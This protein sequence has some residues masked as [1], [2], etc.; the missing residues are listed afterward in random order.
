MATTKNSKAV[1]N[2]LRLKPVEGLTLSNSMHEK[3][4]LVDGERASQELDQTRFF[5]DDLDYFVAPKIFAPGIDA[6]IITH[7]AI[8]KQHENVFN[9]KE[10]VKMDD[11][12]MNTIM[13]IDFKK[14][15]AYHY[16]V[17]PTPAYKE[18]IEKKLEEGK[19]ILMITN[20]QKSAAFVSNKGYFYSLPEMKELARKG[21]EMYQW[22]G[23]G[24]LGYLHEK[25]MIFDEDHAIIGS[26]NFGI[27]STSVSN[28]IAIEFKSKA[29][30]G[31]LIEVFDEEI[32]NVK[33]TKKVKDKT[34]LDEINKHFKW[35]KLLRADIIG[36]IVR[37][38]C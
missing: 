13:G 3:I 15:R 29:I 2:Y 18:Y 9:I 36:D 35:I 19:E 30:A 1:F 26:H 4:F 37:E 17:I 23:D 22:K 25:V 11:D 10:R 14:L 12:I 21:L 16:L 32:S 24:V 7:E 20:S 5:E 28:E 6:R 27:G 38:L 31:R 34:L 33:L 8:L